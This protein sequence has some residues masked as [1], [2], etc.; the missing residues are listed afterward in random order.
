MN[1][2]YIHPESPDQDLLFWR[3]RTPARG[4]NRTGRHRAALLSIKNFVN[5][6]EQAERICGES[7]LLIIQNDLI[8]RALSMV[9]HWKAQEKTIIL[10]LQKSPRELKPDHRSY[11]RWIN[12]LLSSELIPTPEL[13][14][15]GITQLTWGMKLAHGA[16]VPSLQLEREWSQ[17]PEVQYLP[18]FIDLT[19]YESTKKSESKDM[20][21]GWIFPPG[22]TYPNPDTSI[23][24]ALQHLCQRNRNLK[25]HFLG[26]DPGCFSEIPIPDGQKKLLTPF[27]PQQRIS[28]ISCFDFAVLPHST[29]RDEH[30]IQT[31]ILEYLVLKTPWVSSSNLIDPKLRGYGTMVENTVEAWIFALSNLIL[32]SGQGMLKPNHSAYLYGISQNI[33]DHLGTMINTYKRFIRKNQ[34]S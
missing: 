31:R 9:Q 7:D 13:D 12:S 34:L 15:D 11:P 18:S 1:L 29:S 19:S 10:D 28:M 14:P 27:D 30:F 4:L 17:F 3:C 24:K 23:S 33:D 8:G 16:T 21:I 22:E 2:V 25:I 32:E 26:L 20:I 6:T 5:H